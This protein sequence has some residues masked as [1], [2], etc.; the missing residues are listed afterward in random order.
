MFGG[1]THTL[2]FVLHHIGGVASFIVFG[3]VA[4]CYFFD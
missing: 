2:Y 4:L 3:R 1:V